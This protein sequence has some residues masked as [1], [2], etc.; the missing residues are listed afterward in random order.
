MKFEEALTLIGNY[1]KLVEQ[2]QDSY[3]VATNKILNDDWNEF[4]IVVR[5]IEG[6]AILTDYG[7]TANY[8]DKNNEEF[9]RVCK[10]NNILYKEG[11][12]YT[13]FNS[14]QDIENMISAIDELSDYYHENE[15][16]PY[17]E[18][19]K[20]ELE[21][22]NKDGRFDEDSTIEYTDKTT[23]EKK[24]ITFAEFN[25]LCDEEKENLPKYLDFDKANKNWFEVSKEVYV[26]LELAKISFAEY[27]ENDYRFADNVKV[28]YIDFDTEKTFEVSLN[29]YIKGYLVDIFTEVNPE[30]T[31]DEETKT[32]IQYQQ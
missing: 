6:K 3:F 19:E 1:Y 17:I 2:S 27:D 5:N 7:E 32:W 16:L 12:I 8:F 26:K 11:E 9:E 20:A 21:K 30:F 10:K 31:F 25:N 13:G 14:I 22:M 28:R 4:C 18:Q 23:G 29:D 24:K 15:Y